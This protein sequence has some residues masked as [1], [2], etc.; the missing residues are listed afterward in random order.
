M[1]N[2][3]PTGPVGNTGPTGPTG[4]QYTGNTGPTGP[5]W[6]DWVSASVTMGHTEPKDFEMQIRTVTATVPS[7]TFITGFRVST[8]P[9][10]TTVLISSVYAKDETMYVDFIIDTEVPGSYIEI[11]V[12][13]LYRQDV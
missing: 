8:L 7:S 13:Y 12:D 3:G 5:V 11:T 9:S 1:G 4:H 6:N 10:K 2:T